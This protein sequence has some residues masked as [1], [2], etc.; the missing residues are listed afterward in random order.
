MPSLCHASL[1]LDS[2]MGGVGS[3]TETETTS[4][5]IMTKHCSLEHAISQFC[6]VHSR[7]FTLLSTHL[8]RTRQFE[9]WYCSIQS[10]PERSVLLGSLLGDGSIDIHPGH[11]VKGKVGRSNH[12]RWANE[13][14]ELALQGSMSAVTAAFSPTL[15]R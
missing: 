12:A 1:V 5:M 11:F 13:Q 15:P 10:H 9:S 7:P 4:W 14:K 3:E 8:G 2:S 6:Q